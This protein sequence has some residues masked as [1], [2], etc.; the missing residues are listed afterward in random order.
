MT[1]NSPEAV[2]VGNFDG[3]GNL[4]AA[5]AD[6]FDDTVTILHGNGDGTFTIAQVVALTPGAS[7]TGLAVADLDN[8]GTLDLVVANNSGG[9]D[10]T[11]SI[12]VLKGTASGFVLQPEMSAGFNLNVPVAVTVGDLN[13]DGNKDLVVVNEDGDSVSILLGTGNLTF[14]AANPAT[15]SV[16]G[17]PESAAI[18]DFNGDGK[19]DIAT[20]ASLDDKVAVLAG[21][22]DGTFVPA[23]SFDVASGPFGMVTA[24]FNGDHKPDLASVNVE[25]G[26][27]SVLLN[28]TSSVVPT[29]TPGVV[30]VGDCDTSTQVTVNEIITMVNIA[31]GNGQATDC[32]AGDANHDGQITVDEIISAI[33]NALNGCTQ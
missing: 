23:Q 12:N 5:T 10:A 21:N 22:G 14:T 24:D 4:D 6:N 3:D 29:P 30:C 31:L 19:L 1:G 25:G 7:P 26:N 32:M 8:D 2:V 9:P 27:V 18:D 17:L 13:H 11:G 15:T 33:N 20:S 28:V 16:G